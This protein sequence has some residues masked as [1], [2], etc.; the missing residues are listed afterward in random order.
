[1]SKRKSTETKFPIG[2]IIRSCRLAR[3]LSQGDLREGI[4]PVVLSRIENGEDIPSLGTLAK[5]A[6]IMRMHIADFFAGTETAEDL[7]SALDGAELTGDEFRLLYEMKRLAS[8]LS[9]EDKVFVLGMVRH[10][11]A[12]S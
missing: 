9:K 2:K 5:L 6:D 4:H 11:A 1:M 3:G 8:G 7:R 12:H 10:A